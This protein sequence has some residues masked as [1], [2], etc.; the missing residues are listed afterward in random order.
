[1]LGC[2]D[3]GLAQTRH[4]LPALLAHGSLV[5]ASRA[6]LLSARARLDIIS[7]VGSL[8]PFSTGRIAASQGASNEER[9]AELLHGA[10]MVAKAKE[11][12]SSAG[13]VVGG[14]AI[15]FCTYPW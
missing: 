5:D 8:L 7:L 3:A 4:C 11:G 6:W 2:H 9:R 13:D 1:M 10:T 15:D 12:F 14:D